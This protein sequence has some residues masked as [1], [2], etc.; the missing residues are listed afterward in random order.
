[1]LNFEEAHKSS[2]EKNNEQDFGLFK[3]PMGAKVL[4]PQ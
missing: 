4:L 2:E 1:M 3:S